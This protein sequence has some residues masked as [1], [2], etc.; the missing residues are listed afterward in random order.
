M[1]AWTSP[2]AKRSPAEF[3][4]AIALFG[5]EPTF[6]IG[7]WRSVAKQLRGVRHL[8]ERSAVTEQA[9]NG[10]FITLTQQV[11]HRHVDT[12]KRVVGL[13]QVKTLLT[14]EV[15]DSNNIVDA[16]ERLPEHGGQDRFA[17][18]V[19]HGA[20]QAGN[21]HQRRRFALAPTR[22]AAGAHT[23]QQCILAAIAD[24]E[25]LRHGQI[26]EV[27]RFNF[28]GVTVAKV[29]VGPGGWPMATP[30]A[31][32]TV[33]I[34]NVGWW[35]G[36][37]FLRKR[38][39]SVYAGTARDPRRPGHRGSRR[40]MNGSGETVIEVQ[41]LTKRF[42]DTLAVDDVSFEV[43]RG[44]V[45]GFL[46]PNGAGKTTTI[47]MLTGLARPTAGTIRYLGRDVS[48]DVKQAQHLMGIVPDES[49]LYPEL[50]GF[51]NLCFCAALYGM[52][53]ADREQRA[54]ELLEQFG[55]ADVQDR[56]FGAYSR[57][58]KRKLTIA[59][60]MMHE[61]PILFLDE[62]TSGIDVASARQ[63]RQRLAGL[64]ASGTTVFLTTHYIE[65]A[66]RLCDRIAFIVSGKLVQVDTLANLVHDVQGEHRVQIA[67][68]AGI[69]G[70]WPL[71]QDTFPAATFECLADTTLR[72]CTAQ[73]LALAPLIR[74][75]ETH[76]IEV[77]EARLIRPSLEDVFVRITGIEL[78]RMRKEP[79]K[80]GIAT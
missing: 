67:L 36:K 2:F 47:N 15:S 74:F 6:L 52:R 69:Q 59:A 44:E 72:V 46:G 24:V 9:I 54:A 13:Q 19:R 17:G 66:E 12:R 22:V 11:P 73:P 20:N 37:E 64:Q 4:G 16:V 51:Q 50:D 10:C 68:S 41:G 25:H 40:P 18:A 48:R 79:E 56:K 8:R 21:G 55:L 28:H 30:G 62:P 32:S 61:P 53:R 29:F 77:T 75:F 80:G 78:D 39:N 70:L 1:S 7:L 49:N 63:V 31:R 60:G 35:D 38:M 57:G 14:H 26:E 71:L 58:M 33:I 42:G 45:F 23:H 3:H 76:G 27:D 5:H 43:R 34:M 65:E